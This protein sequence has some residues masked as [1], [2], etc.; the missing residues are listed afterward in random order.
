MENKKLIYLDGLRGLGCA[1]VF[2]THF[3]FA[4]YYGMYHFQPESCHLPGN[5]DIVIGRSP[6]NLIFN[7]N[8]AVRL[9]LILSGY[10]L[11]RNYLLTGDR[12][13]LKKSAW[14]RYLR[15]MP[16]V[17][18]TNVVIWL[19]MKLGLYY[20]SQAAVLAGSEEWFRGFN[21]FPADFLQMLKESLYGCF[22]FGT[23]DYNGVLWT[24]QMLFL[25]A[26]LV[27]GLAFLVH[28][29]R[30]RYV[31]YGVLAVLLLRSDFL[32]LY[33]GYVLCDLMHSD[34]PRLHR[35]LSRKWLNWILL[36]AGL[37]FCS[38]PS[39]GFGYEGTVWQIL[40]PFVFVNYYHILGVLCLVLAVLHLEPLQRFFSTK[41]FRYLGRISYSL[42]LIHFLVMA[43]FGAWFLLTFQGILGYNL[44]SLLNLILT[45]AIT[46]ILSELS[47]RY[48]EPLSKKGEVL[49]GRIFGKEK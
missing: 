35:F 20:N 13:H 22:L 28:P 42:Y 16:P 25:G 39:S 34:F 26:Y 10:L 27:Y 18:V 45:A 40:M 37:Y 1:V 8:T 12:E 44:T 30:Y 9:F 21:A 15:L 38:F 19:C 46:V 43:T 33:L 32:A 23:N 31:I 3:V 7:G 5:L 14:K 17:L 24:M 41:M 11:C 48:V 36:L 29:L 2:M 47:V 6:L 4:F 49:I